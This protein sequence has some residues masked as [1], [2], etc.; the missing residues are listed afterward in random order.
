MSEWI[1]VKDK[2]PNDGIKVITLSKNGSVRD[3]DC[4]KS[5]VMRYGNYNNT[6]H[7]IPFPEMSKESEKE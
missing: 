4:L 3:C 5:Y 6:T 1:S 7:W 2:L